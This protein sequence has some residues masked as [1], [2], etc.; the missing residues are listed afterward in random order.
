[1]AQ[2][3]SC[4]PLTVWALIRSLANPWDLWWT[5]SHWN[6]FLS[7]HLSLTLSNVIPPMLHTYFHLH[8][9]LVKMVSRK[10]LIT[11]MQSN[12]FMNESMKLHA[13]QCS[14]GYRGALVKKCFHTVSLLRVK[15]ALTYLTSHHIMKC[16]FLKQKDWQIVSP[17]STVNVS[18]SDILSQSCCQLNSS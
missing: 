3:F 7:K 2:T 1:M 5:K 4:L 8:T 14:F 18:S 12:S 16:W 9:T 11:F 17:N 13:K 15:P 6:R 10:S